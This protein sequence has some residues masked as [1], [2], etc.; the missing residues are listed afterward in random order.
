MVAPL[1]V[2]LPRSN[3]KRIQF[4]GFPQTLRPWTAPS[5]LVRPCG[6]RRPPFVELEFV[7][8]RTHAGLFTIAMATGD[9]PRMKPELQRQIVG[10]ERARSALRPAIRTQFAGAEGHARYLQLDEEFRQGLMGA[11]ALLSLE[12]ARDRDA[13]SA[14]AHERKA[15]SLAASDEERNQLRG[16]FGQ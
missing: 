15:M 7:L 16:M 14:K 9:I 13:V 2:A 3:L 6:L 11:H 12:Y 10:G 1:Y 5:A 4:G 8:F